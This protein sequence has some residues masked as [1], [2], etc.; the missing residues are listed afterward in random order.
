MNISTNYIPSIKG[1]PERQR[2]YLVKGSFANRTL[3]AL[4]EINRENI[5]QIKSSVAGVNWNVK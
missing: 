5:K 2:R 4:A 1:T 3:Q